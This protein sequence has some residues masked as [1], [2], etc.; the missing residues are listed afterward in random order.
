MI[1]TRG[2]E[3]R[4][5]LVRAA[6]GIFL[7]LCGAGCAGQDMTEKDAPMG[8]ADVLVGTFE[9][10][11]VPPGSAAGYTSLSG[12]VSDGP[13]PAPFQWMPIDRVGDCQLVKP[14]VPFCSQTCSGG[15]IC[16]ADEKCQAYPKAHSVGTVRVRG[17]RTTSGATEFS[18][19]SIAGT[20]QTPAGVSLL[21]PAFAEGEKVTLEADGGDYAPF[22][23][24][25]LGVSP[26]EI[27]SGQLAIVPG[28]AVQLAWTPPAR[29]TGSRIY[30]QLDISHH[31]GLKGLLACETDDT[32]A[33]ELPAA[34]VTKLYDLGTAGYPTITVTRYAT[35]GSAV[36]TPG[37]VDLTIFS[38]VQQEVQVPG[39]VSCRV[40]LDCPSGRSCQPN[41]TCS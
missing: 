28:Q 20:Y 21:Y 18:M 26:L 27:K 1:F 2:S 7:W 34:L 17:L 33:L 6:A 8:S 14:Q 10:S 37:R 4:S 3:Y 13:T 38:T 24:Q 5:V 22:T 40:D 12:K 30:I 25:A 15:A 19:S 36:T 23:L 35:R 39:V 16:V 9:L 32:G 11:L 41:L 31:G 29:R